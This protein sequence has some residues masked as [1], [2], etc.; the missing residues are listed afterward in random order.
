MITVVILG[1]AYW[2]ASIQYQAYRTVTY[3]IPAGTQTNQQLVDIPEVIELMVGI[4]DI[5]II[6]NQDDVLHT[7]GPFVVAPHSKFTQRFDRPMTFQGA[8]SLHPDTGLTL[9]VHPAPWQIF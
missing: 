2:G 1:L 5:L 6:D 9:T 3:T 7:F 8:C 4:K